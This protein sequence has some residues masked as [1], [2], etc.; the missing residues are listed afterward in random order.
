MHFSDHQ[1][2]LMKINNCN[3]I[4]NPERIIWNFKKANW[5][6]YKENINFHDQITTIDNV[7]DVVNLINANI[8]QAAKKSIPTVNTKKLKKY[9]P[10]WS[11]E[12]SAAIQNRKRALKIFK[13]NSTPDNFIEFKRCRCRARRLILQAKK[14]SWTNFVSTIDA[15]VSQ[16][17]MWT[18]IRKVKGK[19]TYNP[20]TALKDS[21]NVIVSDKSTM[22]DILAKSYIKNSADSVYCPEFR[23]YKQEKE[24]QLKCPENTES[25]FYNLPFSM[26]EL[27]A[28]FRSCRSSAGGIDGI[29]YQMIIQLPT[30]ALEKLLEVY[31]FI[32]L[33]GVFPSLW[34][35]ALIIP[36]LKPNKNCLDPVSYRPISLLSCLN[37]IL[38]KMIS[39]RLKWLIEKKEI[40]DTYQSGNRKRRSTTDNLALLEH[41]IITAF[42]EDHY[43]IAIFLD[44]NKFFDRISKVVVLERFMDNNV[45]GPMYNYVNNFLSQPQIAVRID[46]TVSS[47]HS[48]DNSIRQGSSLSGDLCNVAVSDINKIIPSDVMHSMFVDDLVVYARGPDIDVLEE[49]LQ[50]TLVKLQQWSK[51]NGLTFSPE[52]TTGLIFTR[53]RNPPAPFLF[54]QN[55]RIKF[56]TNAKWLGL[57]FDSKL[58]WDSHIN[59]TKIK[60]LRALN[61]MKILCNRNWGLRRHTLLKLYQALVLPILD[62]GC[63]IY[64]S[65]NETNLNKLNVIHNTALRMISGAFRTSPIPSLL[66][67]TG[68]PPLQ[69][70]RNCLTINYVTKVS[71]SPSHPVH[72]VFFDEPMIIIRNENLPRSLITRFNQ[73]NNL[74]INLKSSYNYSMQVAPWCLFQPKVQM[75]TTS[76]KSALLQ[77]EVIQLHREFRSKHSNFIFCY[78]DGSK[79]VDNTGG[80]Y[81]F[82]GEVKQFKLQPFCSVYT[83]ELVAIFKCLEKIEAYIRDNLVL[84]N[85]I[86]CS[87]SKSSVS[88]LQNIFSDSILIKIILS[89]LLQIKELGHV[90]QFLWIPS[91][92]GIKENDIVDIAA[93]NSFTSGLDLTFT[94]EDLQN[95]LKNVQ[96]SNWLDSWLRVPQTNKLRVIKSD[97]KLWKSSFAQTRKKEMV[98]CRLRIGH[99]KATHKYLLERKNQPLCDLCSKSPLSVKHWLTGCPNLKDL[100][101][102]YNLGA[103]MTTILCDDDQQI[104]N[105]L[106]FLNEAGLFDKI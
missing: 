5:C 95:T 8:L 83:A 75:L 39:K 53:V 42:N 74:Q 73:L 48:M 51:C 101:R 1:P 19:K 77:Q 46:G 80:A 25:E 81:L 67:E 84:K 29:C 82:N 26:V 50:L 89:K 43:V 12:I 9:T 13:R 40:V 71:S 32:W 35:T 61:I 24:I 30:P 34:K 36:V 106:A 17:D 86:I 20:I 99:C 38:E 94:F 23:L 85:F 6:K 55:V 79:S 62:Y 65:A 72:R 2:I 70:R 3:P 102:K 64:G 7:E 68:Q 98:I 11:D 31:N 88:A 18:Q 87:D 66:C 76:P 63:T 49:K 14:D 60:C 91:H 22:C 28:T 27:L 96:R 15:P 103:S 78:S 16:A 45:G 47:I 37:K 69:V 93:K 10:W 59:E 104:E 52:K 100:R 57:I 44:I 90:V 56:E 54:F 33:T 41:E 4:Y 97:V 105:C 92:S 21:N 58:S